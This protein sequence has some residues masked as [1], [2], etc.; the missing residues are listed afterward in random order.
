MNEIDRKSKGKFTPNDIYE[1]SSYIY[2][3]KKPKFIL[4]ISLGK[5][6]EGKV[7]ESHPSL[8]MTKQ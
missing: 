4:D 7:L 3:L 2:S 1:Q 6:I 5:D 8:E